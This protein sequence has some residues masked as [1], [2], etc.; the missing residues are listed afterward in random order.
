ML[1]D[2]RAEF[3]E[4]LVVDLLFNTVGHTS[5][6]RKYALLLD[7]IFVE[8]NEVWTYLRRLGEKPDRMELIQSGVDLDVYNPGPPDERVIAT[9]GAKP[10]ELIVGFS[11]RWSE[12]KNPL[13]FI[14]LARR[15]QRLPIRFVMTG[16]G[17]MRKEIEQVVA[18]ANLLPDVFHLV[19]EVEDV[20]PWLRSYD[21]LVLPSKLDGRPV[22]VMESLAMGV[23]V[24]ASRVGA[25]SELID[26]RVDGYLCN[27]DRIDEFVDRL[28]Q[29]EGDRALL[30]RMKSAARRKAQFKLDEREMLERYEGRLRA[31]IAAAPVTQGN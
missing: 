22:V 15:L 24:V 8:N 2:L 23:A 29:L 18:S 30:A 31:L 19:G 5:N 11:G 17:T 4:L 27:P 13:A 9:I 28:A 10:G 7:F 1:P 16:A 12:E 26:D 20:A 25:L 21:V 14:E 6:N 3:Q